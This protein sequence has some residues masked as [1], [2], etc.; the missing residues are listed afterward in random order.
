MTIRAVKNARAIEQVEAAAAEPA[1]A[2]PREI[3]AREGATQ[4]MKRAIGAMEKEPLALDAAAIR[5]KNDLLAVMSAIVGAR[6]KGRRVAMVFDIDNT[7][8]DTRHRTAAAATSFAHGGARPMETTTF[9]RVGYRPEDTCRA[10]GIVDAE[11]V[12]AFAKH[13]DQFFWSPANMMLD[14]PLEGPIALAAL[15]RSLGAEL[16][17]LTGRTSDFRRQTIEQLT[18]AGIGPESEAHLIMKSPKRDRDGRL[19]P[20]E[21]FKARE[22]RKIYRQKVSIA[23]FVTEGARDVCWLQKHVPEVRRYLFLEFPIDEPGY[24]VGTQRTVFLPLEMS[25]PSREEVLARA[26]GTKV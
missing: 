26:R 13:F 5:T 18:R 24:R 4:A 1:R 6:A 8:M 16:Y 14:R 3:P 7:L 15:A 23:A 11:V 20:T 2:R 19:E 12:S 25:L 22:L 9:E 17:F 21:K 10:N